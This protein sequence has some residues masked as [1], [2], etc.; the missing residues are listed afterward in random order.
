MNS[1]ESD[2]LLRTIEIAP[3]PVKKKAGSGKRKTKTQVTN[4]NL[5][6]EIKDSETTKQIKKILYEE[7]KINM[8]KQTESFSD[9]EQSILSHLGDYV[10]EPYHIIESYFQGQHLERL[11]RHQIES[12]NHFCN[13]QIQ[14][15][16]QMFNPVKI[17]SENDLIANKDKY[18]FF[19]IKHHIS[20]NLQ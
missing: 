15:T 5:K 11:V 3:E 9:L 6:A 14:R 2:S 1:V 19:F 10:E 12:Y 4:D 8:N 17:H 7:E 18:V 20:L 16:I 13:Y